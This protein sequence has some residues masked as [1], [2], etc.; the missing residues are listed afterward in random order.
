MFCNFSDDFDYDYEDDEGPGGDDYGDYGPGDYDSSSNTGIADEADESSLQGGDTSE[1]EGGSITQDDNDS[2]EGNRKKRSTSSQNVTSN[3][4]SNK[5]KVT[6]PLRRTNSASSVLGLNLLLNP[7]V[8][9]YRTG[10]TQNN[11]EGFKVHK[12]IITRRKH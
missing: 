8:R 6:Q 2:G 7:E 4:K 9:E 12:Y 1:N 5:T 10:L 11:Y 3:K